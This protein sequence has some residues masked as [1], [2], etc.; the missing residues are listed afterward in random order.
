MTGSVS[1]SGSLLGVDLGQRM[2]PPVFGEAELNV[3]LSDLSGT[4]RFHDLTVVVDGKSSAFRSPD[5]QYGIDV[6]SNTFS[7]ADG[8]IEGRFFGPAHDEM[9]GVLHDTTSNVNM[10]AGFGGARD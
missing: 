10:L 1:W 9:A 8:H 7:D 5:L 3:E 4:A 6:A 2:L